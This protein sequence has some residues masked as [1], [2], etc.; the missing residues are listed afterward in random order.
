MPEHRDATMTIT[1]DNQ[2]NLYTMGQ[3]D[4]SSN[5]WLVS[6]WAA[7]QTSSMNWESDNVRRTST[8]AIELVLDKS[9]AGA[10][11]PYAGGEIQSDASA[12]TGTF[13]WHAQA[14]VMQA[15]AVFGLFTYRADWQNQPWTEFDFEFVGADTTKVQLNIHME[16][17]AGQHVSLAEKKG[18]PI[19]VN[20]GFDAAQGV[21]DYRVVVAATGATFLVDGKVVG[22]YG[23]ADMPQGVWQLGPM[24]SY[25]DLWCA[26]GLDSWTGTWAGGSTPLVARLDG[27]ELREGDLT[28]AALAQPLPAGADDCANLLNGTD[29]ADLID[30]KGGNDTI[31][32]GAG[33]DSLHGGAGDDHIGLDAGNDLIDGGSGS[34]WLDIGASGASVDLAIIGAQA[35]GSG[36]DTITGIENVLGGAG[37]DRITGDDSANRLIGN[38]G[39]DTLTGRGGADVIDGGAGDDNLTGGLG[40]DLLS[41]GAGQDFLRLDGGDDFM[42]GGDGVDT[43]FYSGSSA[44]TVNLSLTSAQ[45]TGSGTDT[46]RGIENATGGS[47]ADR[48]TGSAAGNVLNGAAGADTLTGG[49]GRD[50]LQGGADHDRDVFVFNA[51]ADSAVGTAR[52]V[53]RDFTVGLDD[54][55]LRGIDANTALA[56]DQA[57]GFAG[58]TAAAHAVWFTLSGGAFVLSGDVTGDA[59]ADFQIGLTGVAALMA[60]D[61]LL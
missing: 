18:V 58:G 11:R 59:R 1:Y 33:H 37:A 43:L 57:F 8:G 14:P 30:G 56:G 47:G 2:I 48:L 9:A 31:H 21:H 20:L 10:T 36:S 19:I 13:A 29:G 50:V 17:A 23:A 26:Q 41:G 54:I 3:P 16:N 51:V 22:V 52:D 38:D 15:G 6:N 60:S 12:T 55:D 42:D 45:I 25:V 4:P 27:V 32:G 34:D 24:K 61:I 40:N 49:A 44:L 39:A 53:V 7:G 28:A 46:L 35:T 5:G